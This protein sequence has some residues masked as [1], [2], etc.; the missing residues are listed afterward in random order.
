[1]NYVAGFLFRVSDSGTPQVALIEKKRP[2]WQAGKLN[3]IGG[4]IES[5][6]MPIEAMR[7]EF[8]EETGAVVAAWRQFACLNFSQGTVFFYTAI[9]DRDIRSTTDEVVAWYA[10][11]DLPALPLIPNLRWL[12]P[13]AMDKDYVSVIANDPT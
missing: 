5:G 3:G 13:L 1:M 4:K 11:R 6:E 10:L 12:I 7:R 9:E 2:D 8:L